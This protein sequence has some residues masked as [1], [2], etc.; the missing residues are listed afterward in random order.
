MMRLNHL[1]LVSENIKM[2]DDDYMASFSD[3]LSSSAHDAFVLGRN[4]RK[5]S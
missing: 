5:I 3:K 2:T 1:P 4:I